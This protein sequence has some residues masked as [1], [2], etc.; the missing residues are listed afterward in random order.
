MDRKSNQGGFIPGRRDIERICELTF[1]QIKRVGRSTCTSAT[2]VKVR[3]EAELL[4]LC[5]SFLFD[6]FSSFLLAQ[7]TLLL[8][9]AGP[10]RKVSS[11]RVAVTFAGVNVRARPPLCECFSHGRRQKK[12]KGSLG[13]VQRERLCS[14]EGNVI[15]ENEIQSGRQTGSGT[16]CAGGVMLMGMIA[17]LR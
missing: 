10:A 2:A 11:E 4:F 8:R 13:A 6:F 1:V 16:L 15:K 3:P 17:L 12:K 5:F 14:V 9:T 7:P